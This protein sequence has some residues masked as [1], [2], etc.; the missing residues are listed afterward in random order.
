M[1]ASPT[2]LRLTA[3]TLLALAPSAPVLAAPFEVAEQSSITID[4]SVEHTVKP[5]TLNVTL[6]CDVKPTTEDAA[7]NALR[8]K[9]ATFKAHLSGKSIRLN[10]PLNLYPSYGD[11]PNTDGAP[12]LFSGTVTFTIGTMQPEEWQSIRG[13]LDAESCT[14]T[15]DAR[16][17]RAVRYA[18]QYRDQLLQQIDE[19]RAFYE[20]L[21]GKK[22]TKVSNL[23]FSTIPD[24]QGNDYGGTASGFD[25]DTGLLQVVTSLTVT[26]DVGSRTAK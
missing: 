14:A 12:E 7:R 18:R 3:V 17:T 6:T 25:P 10:G 26:F 9:I 5:D 22:L 19:S 8:Q 16:V 2:L 21:L 24:P 13:M 20:D 4:A 1:K 11:T 23:F 15:Y